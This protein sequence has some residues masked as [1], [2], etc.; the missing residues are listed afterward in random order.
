MYVTPERYRTMG[1]GVDISDVEDVE[2]RSILARASS[3][4]DAICAVPRLPQKFDFRGGTITGERHEWYIDPYDRPH[5]YRFRLFHRPVK[6]IDSF[7]IYSGPRIYI[8][9][10]PADMMINQ[11]ASYVEIASLHLTQFG[12]WGAGIVPLYGLYYPMYETDYTYGYEF[13]IVDEVLE[14][15]DAGLFRAQNQYWLSTATTT[16]KK[17]GTTLTSGY[18]VDYTEGT[19][20]LDANPAATDTVTATYTSTLAP[21]IRDAT[22]MIATHMM[23]E[24]EMEERGMAAVGSLSVAE[25][26][27]SRSTPHSSRSLTAELD[28][29]VGSLLEPFIFRSVR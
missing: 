3:M 6:T 16:V 11:S 22:A 21:E 1:Y 24:R 9:I 7:R 26:R 19:V 4:V 25:V 18:T 13:G 28:P 14:P 27:I 8:E 10:P 17:N 23:G 12:I 15:T 5:P 2:L 29:E 20:T